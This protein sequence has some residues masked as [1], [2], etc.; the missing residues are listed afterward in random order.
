MSPLSAGSPLPL[1]MGLAA[2]LAAGGC[3]TAVDDDDAD[4]DAADDDLA[5]DDAADD[6]AADDDAADD[7]TTPEFAEN[8]WPV[9]TAPE[10]LEGTG[11][12]V[13][14]IVPDF[15]REDQ[16][17]NDTSMYQFYGYTLLLEFSAMWCG[18]CNQMADDSEE[19]FEEL[20]AELPFYI[21]TVLVDDYQYNTPD[22]DDLQTW[23]EEYDLTYP[24]LT[25]GA[26]FTTISDHAEVVALPTVLVVDPEMKVRERYEGV[27]DEDDLADLIR[28]IDSEY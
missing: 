12:Q 8:G 24:V 13:G 9:S 17:G 18:P 25:E 5:D 3:T 27:P 4:D 21:V 19:F 28:S 10:G 6:D 26:G 2:L 20:S 22:V 7:D 15:T 14:D 16:N 1:L 11:Y 23:V